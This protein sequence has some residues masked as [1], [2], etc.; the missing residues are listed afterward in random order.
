MQMWTAEFESGEVTQLDFSK[1]FRVEV[2]AGKL[3]YASISLAGITLAGELSTPEHTDVGDP[4]V[5]AKITEAGGLSLASRF[6]G[7]YPIFGSNPST[8]S[9]R[10]TGDGAYLTFGIES[11]LAHANVV[12]QIIQTDDP[13]DLVVKWGDD[14]RKSDAPPGL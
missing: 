12:V 9:G 1:D 13:L 6:A 4:F 5:M 7:Q 10:L 8:W 14:V 11:H 2:P 3:L